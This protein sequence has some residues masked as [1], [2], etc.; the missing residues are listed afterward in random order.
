MKAVLICEVAP[1]TTIEMIMA[2]YPRHA[3]VVEQF[4]KRGEVLGIGPF[5]D[6]Q[7]SLAIFTSQA[8]AEA[9]VGED[10]FIR[11]GLVARYSIKDWAD[12]IS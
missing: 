4:M 3:A 8:A 10:P 5:S 11:E 7:G 9:F 2:V 6:R 12:A 1:G